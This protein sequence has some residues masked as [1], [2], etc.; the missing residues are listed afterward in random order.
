MSE[1]LHLSDSATLPTP[2]PLRRNRRFQIL[3]IGAASANLGLETVEVAYPLL[4]MSLTGSPALAGLFG[5]AQIGT[6]LLVGLPAGAVVDRWDRRRILLISE[7]VRALTLAFI[8]ISLMAGRANFG[9]LILAAVVLGAGTA[10][11]APARMLLIRA[12]VPDHQLTAALSQDEARSGAAALAG[13]PLGGALYLVSRTFPFLAAIAGFVISFV[14]ALLVRVPKTTEATAPDE[15]DGPDGPV[16]PERAGPKSALSP[17]TTAFSGLVELLTDRLLRSA[18]LLISIFYFSI[19]AAILMVMV[20]LREQDHSAGTIGL[21]LS[22]TAV[23][24]LVGSALVPR[25]N[26]LLSPGGLLLSAST[27]TTLAVALLALPF[28]PVWVFAML[29]LAALG[30]P[31]LKILVDIMIFRQTP[32]HRRGR[33][34]AATITLIGAGSPLGSLVGGLALQFLGVTGAIVLIAGAQALITAAGLANRHVRSARW[35]A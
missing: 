16:G 19:T 30:L 9:L 21:A 31:A 2:T 33:A 7:A 23:G 13:P 34:I 6:A 28:G 4:I 14:C 24:M 29:T 35:P 27:L 15:P 8:V 25:L 32:D 12:V 18:L 1:R 22:G 3:W 20:T 10:F 5:F 11:G 17:L 26:R